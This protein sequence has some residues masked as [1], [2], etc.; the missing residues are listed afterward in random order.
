MRA[1]PGQEQPPV[2]PCH[3]A[4]WASASGG[5]RG[6]GIRELDQQ[7]PPPRPEPVPA[8]APKVRS[9]WPSLA[10]CELTSEVQG[11]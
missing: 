1:G 9:A 11:S 4:G 6:T 10:R 7:H 3:P 5:Q 2:L 8:A